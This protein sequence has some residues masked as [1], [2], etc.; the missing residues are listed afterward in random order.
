MNASDLIIGE[1][2]EFSP[3]APA[4]MPRYPSAVYEGTVGYAVASSMAPVAKTHASMI[5]YVP[6]GTPTSPLQLKY[7]LFRVNDAT[8]VMAQDWINT[9]TLKRVTTG[10]VTV[11]ISNA[12]PADHQRIRSA[13]SA[14]GLQVASIS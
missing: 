14:A 9:A 4:L 8:V 10:T 13:L 5:A 2:Y 1:T 7:H 6:A 11:V 3:V 12:T